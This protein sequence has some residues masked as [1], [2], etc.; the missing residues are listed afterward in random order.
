MLEEWTV[1]SL[2]V[3]KCEGR[4]CVRVTDAVV[5]MCRQ[6]GLRNRIQIVGE[7]CEQVSKYESRD[8]AVDDSPNQASHRTKAAAGWQR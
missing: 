8:A 6:A 3:N 4:K 7:R 5:N 2:P 1:R